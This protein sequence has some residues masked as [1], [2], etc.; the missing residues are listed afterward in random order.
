[1]QRNHLLNEIT[2]LKKQGKY[3]EALDLLESFYSEYPQD[4]EVKKTLI[5]LMFDF[6][7]HLN[8][9]WVCQHEKASTCYKR[10]IELD[11]DNYR[12][13][14]NLGIT[15]FN[16]N[17]NN[18]ALNAYNEAIKIKPDYMYC[19]YNIGLLYEVHLG[20]LEIA[21]QYYE[22]ALSF[23]R[24]F[25]Y[26]FQAL[27]DV[28]KK[29]DYVRENRMDFDMLNNQTLIKCQR[30]GEYNRSGSKFCNSCGELIE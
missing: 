11:P 4:T 19:Y 9:E 17:E 28:R 1:V 12:A 7:A 8:D 15:Y 16:L 2:E 25:N 10:I 3:Q 5:E 30:C 27:N 14:Y 23:N 21:A 13:W 18:N 20:E 29:I 26:A 6:G 22:K 24:D